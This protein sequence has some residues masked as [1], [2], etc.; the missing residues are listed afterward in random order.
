[1][2]EAQSR[3]ATFGVGISGNSFKNRARAARK[4]YG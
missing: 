1:V 4:V 2:N 3:F